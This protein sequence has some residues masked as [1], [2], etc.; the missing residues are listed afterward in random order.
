[1]DRKVKYKFVK[2]LLLLWLVSVVVGAMVMT[3]GRGCGFGSDDVMEDGWW[4]EVDVGRLLLLLVLDVTLQYQ[5]NT[6]CNFL[7]SP[8]QIMFHWSV[9]LK[10]SG[11]KIFV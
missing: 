9:N 2:Y 10:I 1:M 7:S 5:N 3:D 6:F 8:R 11:A 4:S